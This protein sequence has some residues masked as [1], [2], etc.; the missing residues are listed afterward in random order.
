MHGARFGRLLRTRL[1]GATALFLLLG[2]EAAGGRVPQAQRT[3]Q[4]PPSDLTQVSIENLMNMEVTSVSKK[5]QKISRTGA[6]IFLITK[7]DIRRAGAT[8]IPDLLR[9]VPGL[10]VA[11]INANIWAISSRG[12]NG[13]FSNKLLVMLDGRSVYL[14]TF[15][16]VF[17]DVLD[18]P[19]ENIERIEVIRGPG[20]TTWGA[21]AVN[22]VINIITKKASA[23]RGGMVVAGGG[24]LDQGFGTVQYGGRLAKTTDYRI[25]TKY[26]NQYHLPGVA[27]QNGGDGWHALRGGFRTDSELSPKDNLTVQGDLYS[28]RIGDVV[29]SLQSVASPVIQN[30][31]SEAN[32]TGGYVRAD[33]NHRHSARSD[34]ALQLSFDRYKR[35]DILRE[36]RNTLTIDLQHHFAWAARQDLVWGLGYRY[37]SSTTNGDLFTFFLNP[38]DLDTHLFSAFLQDE[39]TL[40]P[41]RL[42]LTVGT[43]LEHNHYTGFGVMP[44]ARVAWNLNED[45]MVWAAVSRSIRTPSSVDTAMEANVSGFVPPGGPPVLIRIVGN[46]AFQDEHLVAYEGGYRARILQRLTLDLALYYNSYGNLQTTEPSTSFFEVTPPPPHV[47]LPL[48][49][50]NLMHGETHGLEVSANWKVT[51]RWTLTPGYAFEQIH[52][53]L[54]STSQDTQSVSTGLGSSPRHWARLESHVNLVRSLAWDASAN[55]ADRLPALSVPSH[56]RLDTQLTWRATENLSLSIVGQ[57][58]LRDRHL[59]FFNPQGTGMANLVSAALT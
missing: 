1:A 14:P 38:A 40:I 32:V 53:H 35:N 27:G 33:W 37:S 58:L 12:F 10:N 15:S 39:F 21:N 59:E 16:G 25:F 44:S 29:S 55:F 46:P 11:Q 42:S 28:A 26:F 30:S 22:G 56:T 7:E 17:W 6:A 36:E 23:T 24:N 47:V 5:E 50:G 18:L 43:K 13:E 34:T 19:L 9:M 3:S 52:L 8:N 41:D 4:S 48:V 31:F 2:C 45:Q 51:G 54:D 57:N 20:G 49:N